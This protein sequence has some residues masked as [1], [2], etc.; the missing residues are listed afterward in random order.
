MNYM[1][2]IADE[3]DVKPNWMKI[4]KED[5]KLGLKVS[6]VAGKYQ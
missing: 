1:D 3:I 6:W 4:L 2:E 5:F